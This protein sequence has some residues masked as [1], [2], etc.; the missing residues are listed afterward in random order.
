MIDIRTKIHDRYSIEFKVGFVAQNKSGNNDFEINTWFYIPHSLDINALTYNKKHFYTDIKSNVRLITPVISLAGMTGG[1]ETPLV[2]LEKAIRQLSGAPTPQNFREYEYQVRLSMSILKS[3]LR[4]EVIQL[5]KSTNDADLTSLCEAY[6]HNVKEVSKSYRNLQA[7]LPS[8]GVKMQHPFDFGDE[9]LSTTVEKYTFRILAHLEKRKNSGAEDCIVGLKKLI[10]AEEAYRKERGF[11]V[12]TTEDNGTNAE[13]IYRQGILKKYIESDL[14]LKSELK[15]DSFVAE[16]VYFSIAAGISMVFATA[17]AFSIQQK[18]G[19]FTMP[20]FVALVV[21]YMLKDRIKSLMRH[22]FAHKLGPKHFDNRIKM[23]LKDRQ[24]GWSKE[25]A[26]FISEEKVPAEISRLRSRSPLVEAE[27][28]I[29]DEKIL[30][31]RKKV[32]L[33]RRELEKSS[34]YSFD[35][36]N[37]IMRIYITR[38]I[39]KADNPQVP[40]YLLDEESNISVVNAPKLY[41]LNIIMQLKYENSTE[42]KRFRIGFSRSGISGIEELK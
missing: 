3:A 34:C 33:D 5:K 25:A 23:S 15:S 8:S 40:L 41:Y 11:L 39:R 32:Q 37:D 26:D 38:L 36:I 6:I 17:I 19:N 18:Y 22:Y 20:L 16:Q 2:Y 27:N 28:R 7:C 1:P 9:F 13:I 4:N 35:G 31:Y 21:S 10:K 14:Y 12:I 42:Y 29:T 24:I 30:L